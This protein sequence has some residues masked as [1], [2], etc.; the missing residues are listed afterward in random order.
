MSKGDD[1]KIP[2]QKV[3]LMRESTIDYPAREITHPSHI[4]TLILEYIGDADREHFVIVMLSTK[5]KVIGIHTVSIGNLSA[6]LVHPREV[7]K[8]AILSSA[9]VLILAHNHPSGEVTPSQEDK[10]MTSRLQECGELLGIKI[11][12]HVIVGDSYY[13]FADNQLL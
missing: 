5:H 9:A 2:V 12:D 10:D 6:S 1:V 13:S 7:F 3:M 4:A 8:A 11:L